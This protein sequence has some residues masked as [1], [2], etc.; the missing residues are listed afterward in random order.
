MKPIW[1]EMA[2]AFQALRE[3]RKEERSD[4][5]LSKEDGASVARKGQNQG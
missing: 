4:S 1:P 3:I 5:A 2:S